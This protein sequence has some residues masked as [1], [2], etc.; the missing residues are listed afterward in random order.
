MGTDSIVQ[1]LF[2]AAPAI[3]TGKGLKV[4][5]TAT[6]STTT[7]LNG[8]TFSAG[9]LV[10]PQFLQVQSGTVDV[11]NQAATIA[12]WSTVGFGYECNNQLHTWNFQPRINYRRRTPRRNDA[13]YRDG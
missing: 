5:G 6:L 8:G 7:T 2:G 3:P 10:N 11:T 12:P 13:E 4:D 1:P 9:Q